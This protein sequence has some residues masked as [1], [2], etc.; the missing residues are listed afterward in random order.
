MLVNIKVLILKRNHNIILHY[1][2]TYATT[3]RDIKYARENEFL[4]AVSKD[5][6]VL[7]S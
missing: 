6:L 4:K 2:S 3:I 5:F 7:V 1:R